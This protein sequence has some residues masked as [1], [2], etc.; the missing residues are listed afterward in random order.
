MTRIGRLLREDGGFTMLELMVVVLLLSLLMT[1]FYGFLFGGER[2]ARDGRDWL[3]A[4]QAARLA[5]DRL[6]RELREADYLEIAEA[7]RVKFGADFNSNNGITDAESEIVTYAYDALSR[8]LRISAGSP[9]VT[10]VLARNVVAFTLSYFG[11]EP[12]LD[13]NFDGTVTGAE[14]EAGVTYSGDSGVSLGG[15]ELNRISL[16]TFEMTVGLRNQRHRYRTSVELR[17]VFG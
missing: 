12:S 10:A 3:E 17:N 8:E 16:V 2:A 9:L 7:G 1:V 14:I 11:S 13:S 5:L 4:N 6:S 15:E